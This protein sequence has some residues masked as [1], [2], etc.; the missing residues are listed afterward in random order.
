MQLDLSII[1]QCQLDLTQLA[2]AQLNPTQ[3]DL[4]VVNHSQLNLTQLAFT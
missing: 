4:T 1:N 2:W 3:V